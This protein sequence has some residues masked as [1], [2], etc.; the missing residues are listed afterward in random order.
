MKIPLRYAGGAYE[1]ELPEENLAG[2]VEPGR[3][4][5]L[6]VKSALKENRLPDRLMSGS[7]RILIIINDAFRSTP[8]DL[9]LD[10]ILPQL[11]EKHEVQIMVATG[12]H[13]EPSFEEYRSL[14]GKYF[15]QFDGKFGWSNSRDFVSFRKAGE[16][17]DGGDVYIHNHFFDADEVI[18][19]GSVEPHY[20]AGFT[21]GIKSILPGLGYYK[22]IEHNHAKAISD[23]SQP[24]ATEG[25]PVWDE[26]WETLD[27]IDTR[28][29]FSYQLVKDVDHNIIGLFS[30][31]LKES[32]LK[33]V[34]FCRDIYIRRLGR[35]YSLVVAEHSHP[36]DRNLYQLQ[37]CFENTKEGVGDGGT[38]LMLSAC[39]DGIG[40]RDFF[41]LAGKYPDPKALLNQDSIGFDLGIHKLYRT[42]I[43]TNR[44]NLRLMSFLPEQDVRRVYI[45]P[46]VDA[47]AFIKELLAHDS[48]MQILIVKDAGHTVLKGFE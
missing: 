4:K 30:G 45:E 11:L 1:L 42:A 41:D 23:K 33:A 16:W 39:R 18:L 34:G 22:S 44:I 47:N 3:P 6:D 10:Q 43:L 46:V 26:L 24:G 48:E 36:L 20:F 15:E 17:P 14:I 40:T 7:L 37:K 21:G 29:I 19:I 8:S 9:I 12:L 13:P 2:V 31:D 38:L 25:N 32:Y 28:K 27:L 35:K 5:P